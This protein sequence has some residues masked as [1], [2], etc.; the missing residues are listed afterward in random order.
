MGFGGQRHSPAALLPAERPG[1]NGTRD[2]VNPRLGLDGCGT[3]PPLHGIR[4]L[5]RPAR[6]ESLYRL[7]CSGLSIY[8]QTLQNFLFTVVLNVNEW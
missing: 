5:D 3:S 1:T 6:G 7:Y 4:S 2:W 8:I